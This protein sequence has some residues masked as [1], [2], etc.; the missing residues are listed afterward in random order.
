MAEIK[1]NSLI[2][3]MREKISNL[4]QNIQQKFMDRLGTNNQDEYSKY[5]A[6]I[7]SFD[8]EKTAIKNEL[9]I[10]QRTLTKHIQPLIEEKDQSKDLYTNN[11]EDLYYVPNSMPKFRTGKNPINDID[12]FISAF[13]NCMRMNGL[14]PD[15]HGARLIASCLEYTDLQWLRNRVPASLVWVYMIP[16]MREIFGDPEK[17][18]KFLLSMWNMKPFNS[19]SVTQF[20]KRFQKAFN[21]ANLPNTDQGA[22]KKFIMCLPD[23]IKWSIEAAIIEKR[24]SS[25][26]ISVS[27]FSMR[28]SN[29]NSAISEYS[30]EK[31]ISNVKKKKKLLYLS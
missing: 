18:S 13:E 28:F 24:L 7:V 21:G 23:T 29:S 3:N 30:G 20:S 5:T 4:D 12:E 27:Q 9:S 11:T 16:I 17:E 22:V 1:L 31:K 15:V 2:C 25:D 26:F 19:E 10:L 8:K 6:K 14:A